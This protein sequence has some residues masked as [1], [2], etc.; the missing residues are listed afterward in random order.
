MRAGICMSRDEEDAKLLRFG[1]VQDLGMGLFS[2]GCCVIFKKMGFGFCP[3]S[4]TLRV[5]LG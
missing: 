2:S 4:I 1:S 5:Q 3:C